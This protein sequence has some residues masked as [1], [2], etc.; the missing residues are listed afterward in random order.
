MGNLQEDIYMYIVS[1]YR[2]AYGSRSTLLL[3]IKKK[4][5]IYA[6]FMQLS[7]RIIR[8]YITWFEY[9]MVAHFI[10]HKYG[11]NQAFRFVEGIWFHRKSCQIRSFFRKGP[12]LHHTCKTC[13]KFLYL[14]SVP[15]S[16]YRLYLS[17][18]VTQKLPQICTV[19]LR[20]RI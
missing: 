7:G 17:Y 12:I 19:I 14:I 6:A 9:Q 16:G 11:V 18:W 8:P 2:V 10:M 3:K 13:S 20:I 4:Y 5:T 1:G 15:W